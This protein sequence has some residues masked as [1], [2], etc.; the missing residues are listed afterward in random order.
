MAN[1]LIYYSQISSN[2]YLFTPAKL[3]SPR[4]EEII[5]F[6]NVES[7]PRVLPSSRPDL[8]EVAE[9]QERPFH[10]LSL[11]SGLIEMSVSV[12]VL[13]EWLHVD[14]NDV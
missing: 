7:V 1:T 9:G 11:F 2:D 10:N 3:L 6:L 12:K 13:S 8:N 14:R 4:K 5:H